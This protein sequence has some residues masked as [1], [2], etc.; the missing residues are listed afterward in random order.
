MRCLKHQFPDYKIHYATKE[1]FKSLLINNPYIDQ[2]HVLKESSSELISELKKE[3]FDLILD[4][5]NNIRTA[6]IWSQLR[7]K[8]FKVDKINWEKWLMVNLKINILPY[9]HIVDRY[10]E[11]G[12]S[13]G[14]T[15]DGRGLDYFIPNTCSIERFKL[16]ERY[17]VY[18]IGGQH[19]TKKLPLK[20]Q[21]ELLS[22]IPLPVILIGGKEDETR[23]GELS[24]SLSHVHNLCGKMSIDE[25]AK[26]IEGGEKL[27][28]H[29]TG[30]MH[31]GAALKRP[32][33]SIW[34]N[35]I[36]EFGMYP[37][38]PE[39]Y[40]SKDSQMLEIKDL[41]CRPCSKIGFKECPKGHFDCMNAIDFEDL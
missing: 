4:L 15:N 9:Q 17:V 7:V 16:P 32:I 13:L 31:I 2:L 37:Y 24:A 22:K 35:T 30:M 26:T 20:K 5:H 23:G 33:V 21:K 1:R 18:A 12:A 3:K 27:Y 36:P 11:T 28:T 10:I 41:Q 39:T 29:D 14:L 19:E 38:Y 40:D 34:G 25:S 8:R 6:N